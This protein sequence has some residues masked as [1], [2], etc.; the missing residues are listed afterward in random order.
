MAYRGDAEPAEEDLDSWSSNP[1]LDIWD[2][3]SEPAQL[4][5]SAISAISAVNQFLMAP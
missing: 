2:L 4:L 5:I 3:E 1:D